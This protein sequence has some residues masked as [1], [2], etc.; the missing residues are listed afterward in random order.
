MNSKKQFSRILFFAILLVIS[1]VSVGFSFKYFRAYK[2]ANATNTYNQEM[3]DNLKTRLDSVVQKSKADEL[4]INGHYDSA[5]A[6]YQ[7][8]PNGAYSAQFVTERK[9]IIEQM[10]EFRQ[11]LKTQTEQAQKKAEFSQDM[12]GLKI[13]SLELQ[14]ESAADSLQTV[15]TNRIEALENQLKKKDQELA[16]VPRIERLTFHNA[17]GTK[18]NYFGEVRNG[19]ANGQGIG[20][21]ATGSVYDGEWKNNKK[22]GKGTYKWV[23]G[24]VYEG[25][26]VE[27][28]REGKGTYY[29]P[30]GDKYVGDWANDARNGKGVLYDKEGKIIVQ[31]EWK[32]DEVAKAAQL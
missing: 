17:N 30:N 1:L 13:T 11:S 24:E 5:M 32:N 8:I 7:A 27:E 9:K 31:G 15:L 23:E 25:D 16:A 3:V 20:S 14:H 10:A 26:F 6:A 4:F 28:K 2:S 21:H 12:L 18:I 22:H 29:W 19:R